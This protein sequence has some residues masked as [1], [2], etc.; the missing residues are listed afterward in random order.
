MVRALVLSAPYGS[1]HD[2]AAA[3]LA[4]AF[5]AEGA[6]VEVADHFQRFVSPAFARLSRAV[7]WAVLRGAPALWGLAYGLSAHIPTRSPAMAGMDRLGARALG[8]ALAAG[9]YHLVVHT[10][11]T[12]AGALA[13]LRARGATTIPHAVVLTDF[14]AHPQWIYPQ[15]D[16]YFVPADPLREAFLAR[17]LP[18]ERVV[19]SGIPVGAAFTLPADRPRLRR[20]LGL[21]PDV[22]AVLVV[23]G[24]HG[25][26]GGIEEACRVLADLGPPFQAVVVCGRHARLEA[27][28]RRRLGGD[29]RFRVLGYVAEMHRVTGAVDL[30]LTKAGG[31]TCAEALALERPLVLYRSLPGQ[32]RA[33][34][35][36]LESQGAAV[37]AP[38]RRTLARAL[39]ELLTTPVRRGALVAAATRL[40]R[41]EAARTVV[42]EML[43]L[44][45]RR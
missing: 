11:P 42:K 9:G 22:P 29:P 17:G 18:G 10:H 39:R 20:D 16:R 30:V 4:E 15:V 37:R 21:D 38:D 34:A 5:R 8:R 14:V 35:I 1:G 23:G 2:R 40:R 31:V 43:A 33:N 27:R 3:A 32:E 19:T 7:F 26:L 44:L 13:W 28:L 45:E 12:P 41:P 24:M 25:W 36:F 6:G